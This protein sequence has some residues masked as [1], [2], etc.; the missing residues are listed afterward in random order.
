MKDLNKKQISRVM[1]KIAKSGHKKK[2]RS[3][4]F[5]R[6]MQKKSVLARK[7]KTLSTTK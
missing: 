2:P 1:S 7:T 4:A 3:K 6:A 5:Y